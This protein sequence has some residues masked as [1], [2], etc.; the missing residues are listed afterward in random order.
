MD[1]LEEAGWT[2]LTTMS[3]VTAYETGS[4]LY[5]ELSFSGYVPE[6]VTD[7][8]WSALVDVLGDELNLDPSGIELAD[9]DDLSS[10]CSQLVIIDTS[11]T[12]SSGGDDDS[13]DD[14]FSSPEFYII[15]GVVVFAVVAVIIAVCC[16]RSRSNNSRSK[17]WVQKYKIL[18]KQS[19]SNRVKTVSEVAMGDLHGNMSHLDDHEDDLN[20][21]ATRVGSSGFLRV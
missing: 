10:E 5:L 4:N 18:M 17:E 8:Q 9:C 13:L 12:V 14:F 6:D 11:A 2:N 19:E 7:S 16:I 20:A 15:V 3:L 1:L 21:Q